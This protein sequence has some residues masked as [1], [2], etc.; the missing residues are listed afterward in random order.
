MNI[1]DIAKFAGVSPATIS[2]VIHGKDKSISAATRN[3]VLAVIKEHNYQPYKEIIKEHEK[4]S[5]II[6][7]VTDVNSAEIMTLIA[8]LSAELARA[9]YSLM[10]L[11]SP[12][13]IATV[14]KNI[15]QQHAEAI[16]VIMKEPSDELYKL[17]GDKIPLFFITDK[18]SFKNMVIEPIKAQA[19]YIVTKYL[20]TLGHR[21]ILGIGADS[22]M[23]ESG[24][25]KAISKEG[26]ADGKILAADVL[27]N[28]L[29]F[30][31]SKEI[32]AVVC[33]DNRLAGAAIEELKSH[34][35]SVPRDI[36]VASLAS[37]DILPPMFDRITAAK[38][39]YQLYAQSVA[40]KILAVLGITAS[41]KIIGKAIELVNGTTASVPAKGHHG[42][43]IVVIGSINMDC[44]IYLEH[45]PT[46]GEVMSASQVI[47]SPGGKGANQ[48]V[49]AARL[50][51][52]TLLIGAMGKDA[53]SRT[54]FNELEK[55]HVHSEGIILDAAL[56]TGTA[57]INVAAAGESSI[58][59]SAGAN[60]RLTRE[61]VRKNKKYLAGAS[62][63]LVSTEIPID[64]V[65]EMLTLCEE[66]NI[67]VIMKPANLDKIPASWL[68]KI[69][70]L[71]PSR[72]ELE[73]LE[74]S[75]KTLADKAKN[76][77]SLGAEN[78]I[79]TLGKQGS[80]LFIAAAE[81]KFK[82]MDIKAVDTTGGADAFISA[83]AVYLSEEMD[84]FTAIGF[85]TYS[86]GLC[87]AGRGVQTSLPPRSLLESYREEI[88]TR[89]EVRCKRS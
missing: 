35:L 2:K 72:R 71:V 17:I 38:I 61:L 48:A 57:Y 76:L 67:P 16:L 56:D 87:V 20:L 50:G 70:Y 66:Q 29:S 19:G 41:Q 43:K 42:Q 65:D 47:N 58:V 75:G 15:E 22:S 34:G 11:S 81:Y 37:D 68:Q 51:A 79:L 53:A 60:N 69:K 23:W 89:E 73:R 84:I 33:A 63:A 59:I 5:H 85:A 12:L 14:V 78:V 31:L 82:A 62:Y 55:N 32:T 4:K 3:K 39:N 21:N 9:D 46:A 88:I 25:Y 54:I 45:L 1:K 36:S 26:Q 83:L 44:N 10:M 80:I 77:I 49:G 52:D 13:P 74:L 24:F 30:W 86:A 40:Q 27:K 8:S 18:D 28:P 6:A 64:A 7:V